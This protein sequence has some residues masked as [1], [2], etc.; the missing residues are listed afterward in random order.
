MNDLQKKELDLFKA[1]ASVCEKHH[2]QY[3]LV[4]GS[5][6]P[7]PVFVKNITYNIFLWVAV[8]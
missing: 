8:L 2:L 5:A 3:F 4:G 6:K 1:F 7:L